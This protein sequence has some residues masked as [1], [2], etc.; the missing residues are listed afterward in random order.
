MIGSRTVRWVAALFGF[1]VAFQQ[2]SHAASRWE[3]RGIGGGGALFSAAISPHDPDLL[4]MATDMTA[5]FRSD[6][7]GSSWEILPFH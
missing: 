2:H 5:V 7:F 3:L 6:N 4:Y 1:L